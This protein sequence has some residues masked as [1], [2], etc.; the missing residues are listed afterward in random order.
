MS[1]YTQ[2]HRLINIS[3][4]SLG[5]DTFLIT[6]FKGTEYISKPFDFEI[7]ALSSNLDIEPEQ[8]IGKDVTVTIQNVQERI[9]HGFVV[10]FVF[11]EIKADD[12]REYKFTMVPWLWFLSQ[13]NDHRVFQH[14]NTKEIVSTIFNDLGF[15]D[16]EFR[17]DG[18]KKREYCI[19]HN[20]SDF[21]FVSRLLEED[22][23]SYFFQHEKDKHQLILVDENHAYDPCAE[24]QLEYSHGSHPGPQIHRWEHQH[25]FRKGRWTLNDYDFKTPDKDLK[26]DT[27]TVSSFEKNGAYEH[28]EYPGL[29]GKA[30]GRELAK[31]RMVAEESSRNLVEAGSSYSSLYAGGRF[32]LDKHTTKKEKG[33]YILH[34]VTHEAYDNTYINHDEDNDLGYSNSFTCL[35]VDIHIRPTIVHKRPVMR[36]PQTAVVVG[37]AGEEIYVDEFG[38]I[39]VQ[40]IW[41]REGKKNENSTCFMRVAQTW[42]GNKWGASFIPRIGHEVIVDFFD[43]DPDRPYISG[44]VYNG[45]NRP[46]YTSK[47]QSGIKSRSTKGGSAS[48]YNEL[49]FDD[50]LGA[51]EVYIQAE[52]DQNNLVKNDE[53][54]NVGNNRT[55]NVGNDET[56]SIGNNRTGSVGVDEKISIGSNRTESVGANETISIGS[57]RTEQVGANESISIGSNRVESVGA[58][59]K[60]SIGGNQVETVGGN[61]AET[62]TVAKA[63][64]I[65]AAYQIS[66]G[67][68][69]NET[70]GLSSTEQV[71]IMKHIL[72]GKRFELAVG[73]SSLVLNSDG[74]IVLKGKE[75][76]IESG[77]QTTVKGKVVEIN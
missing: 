48:N 35:P 56:I 72:A 55:E 62:I 69:K 21:H 51:E 24:F 28:Y 73:D 47:T 42:A 18:G 65:G 1:Q 15:T 11:G 60:V 12:L 64:S 37:P 16:F 10:G 58:N 40:F 77:Q 76:L 5:Q 38:S 45:K 34:S 14:Q 7:T 31:K 4:F 2:E 8:I 61:K 67:A 27:P 41:D 50:K 59:E 20:E 75:I 49:R 52:K 22:G 26:A 46:P 19:Q 71:G 66:V 29:Y 30:L 39:K 63:L 36:G 33:E 3:D 43:G 13:T 25:R 6:G 54:T 44:T 53:T 23:I 17:T 74:T 57:N 32:C 68:A 70:V 9:F